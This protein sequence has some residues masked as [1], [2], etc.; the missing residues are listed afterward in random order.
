V[1]I[2]IDAEIEVP[3]EFLAK[4]NIPL[5]AQHVVVALCAA[6]LKASGDLVNGA[7][8]GADTGPGATTSE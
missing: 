5:L 4:P 1:R 3:P 8:G 7:N 6:L 2:K